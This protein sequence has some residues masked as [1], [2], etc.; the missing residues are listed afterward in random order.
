MPE[1]S[2]VRAH[3][4]ATGG[5]QIVPRHWLE[6]GSPFPQFKP[7]PSAKGRDRQDTTKASPSGSADTT[8]EK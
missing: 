6:S 8:K 3:N 2:F 5:I 1:P 4:T 7:L